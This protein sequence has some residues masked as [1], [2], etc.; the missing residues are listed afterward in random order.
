MLSVLYLNVARYAVGL[1]V[2]TQSELQT[3]LQTDGA[4]TCTISVPLI[5]WDLNV[6]LSVFNSV[7]I[8]SSYPG[9]SQIDLAT[10]AS[11]NL[12]FSGLMGKCLTFEPRLTPPA[13]FQI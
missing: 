13:T 5:T 12:D 10:S 3:C 4:G 7:A 1:V 2:T 8:V 9:G 6:D 11:T